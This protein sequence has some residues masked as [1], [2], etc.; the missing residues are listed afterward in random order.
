MKSPGNFWTRAKIASR[1][2]FG[3][4]YD[5]AKN[6]PRRARRTQTAVTPEEEQF[7]TGDRERVIATLLDFRRNNPVVKSLCRLRETDVVGAGIQPQAQ[8]GSPELD[9]LLE[10]L[11]D[12]WSNA[13]EVTQTMDLREVQR[14]LASLPLI[15]GD[16]GLLL[17][18]SGRVQVVE[19]DRIGT[20]NVSFP[21]QRDDDPTGNVRNVGGV[22]INKQ[23]RPVAYHVG[24]RGDG[25]SLTNVRRIPARNFIFHKKRIR[26][27][28]VRGVPELATV[29]DDIQDVDE[30]DELEMVAAKVSATLA[31]A[32]KREGAIDYELAR[33]ADDNE[34]DRL[35]NLQVGAFQYLEP[36]E[37]V[38]VISG[39]RPNVNSIDYLVYRLRKVGATL[40]VPVEFLLMTIGQTSFSASQGMVLLYQQTV[41]NE[42]RSLYPPLSRLWR[43]KVGRWLA[44]L[45]TQ[46][47]IPENVRAAIDAGEVKPFDVVWQP[48]GFRWIN[49]VAQVAAD[50]SY[51]QMGAISL[52]DVCATFGQDVETVL[53]RKARNISTAKRIAAENGLSDWRELMNQN[54]TTSQANLVELM[55]RD[56]QP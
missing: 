43:W 14:Q 16:G 20:E 35:Q 22:E 8:T 46:I 18:S 31:V 13:P 12:G 50:A 25:G 40:G 48:P 39:N 42:Q 52:D 33:R 53:Q 10:S 51:L 2:L 54:R 37:D 30:Y 1:I 21:W 27:S 19:G 4:G 7:D 23:G 45:D 6:T 11:W 36:G 38:Q 5:A 15:F 9:S 17:T 34:D 56:A 41:E 26:P 47:P 55:E 49:R 28:Q 29:C 24:T 44:G 3:R 32:V